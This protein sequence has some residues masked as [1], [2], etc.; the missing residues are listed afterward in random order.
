MRTVVE[1]REPPRFQAFRLRKSNLYQARR[2]IEKHSG[3]IDKVVISKRKDL[4]PGI[5]IL[6]AEYS[7]FFPVGDWVLLR[8]DGYVSAQSL[9]DEKFQR[10]YKEATE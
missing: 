2:L 7:C 10:L 3:Y 4:P 1:R 9:T 5:W 6:E 8:S